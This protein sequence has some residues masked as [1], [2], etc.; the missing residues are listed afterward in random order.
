MRA[1]G[2]KRGDE[3]A[4]EPTELREVT[5]LCSVDDLHRLKAFL[6]KVIEERSAGAAL[7]RG[8]NL[9]GIASDHKRGVLSG[10][11]HEHLRDHD[12][13]W[14]TDESDL[15]LYVAK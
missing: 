8:R 2:Y 7:D 11:W 9:D 10:P 14:K 12:K 1:F 13:E 3:D 4:E 6:D 5:F 15:I